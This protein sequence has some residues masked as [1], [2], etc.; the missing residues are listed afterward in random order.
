MLI[1]CPQCA[2]SYEISIAALGGGRSV[3]CTRCRNVWFASAP[4]PVL[5]MAGTAEMDSAPEPEQPAET[6]PPVPAET[7]FQDDAA[8][9][10]DMAA[11]MAAEV[12]ETGD[13]DPIIIDGAPP[14]APHHEHNFTP[15]EGPFPMTGGD[16]AAF[17]RRRAVKRAKQNRTW[18]MPKFHW[19]LAPLPTLLLGLAAIIVVLVGWRADVVRLLPQT[20]SFYSVIGLGV[21]LR[22]LEFENIKTSREIHDGIPVMVVEGEIVSVS[23]KAVDIPRLRFGV[24]NGLGAEIYNWTAMPSRTLA[25]PGDRV[26]FRSRLASPP[27]ETHDISVRFYNRRDSVAGLR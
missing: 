9:V 5:E 23:R 16:P 25:A 1:A 17:E 12:A 26:P 27:L 14:L 7:E 8:G 4:E 21:N 15:G 22:G 2:T 13:P 20:A 11:A 10:D 3:R 18:T 24:R 6:P 19:P